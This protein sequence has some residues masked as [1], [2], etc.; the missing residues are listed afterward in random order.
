MNRTD[1]NVIVF[2]NISPFASWLGV[3]NQSMFAPTFGVDSLLG[4]ISNSQADDG[5]DDA[6]IEHL[7]RL[8]RRWISHTLTRKQKCRSRTNQHFQLREHSGHSFVG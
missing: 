4:E 7:K 5:D 6:N 2:V 8:Q 1:L 3:A